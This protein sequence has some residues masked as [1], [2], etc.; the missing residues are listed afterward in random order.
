MALSRGQHA[1]HA[2]QECSTC[3]GLWEAETILGLGDGHARMAVLDESACITGSFDLFSAAKFEIGDRDQLG[4]L[5][6]EFPSSPSDRPDLERFEKGWA[7]FLK[8]MRIRL[9]TLLKVDN[10]SMLLGA[11]ASRPA[12]RPLLGSVPLALEKSLLDEGIT[13]DQVRE[14][15]DVFYSAVSVVAREP[16]RVQLVKTKSWNAAPTLDRLNRYRLTASLSSRGCTRGV[17]RSLTPRHH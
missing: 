15:L 17:K 13:N 2:K 4:A 9:G 12:G 7:N 1:C 6:N 10:V 14:W 5:R 3:T 16:S 11:G 8:D